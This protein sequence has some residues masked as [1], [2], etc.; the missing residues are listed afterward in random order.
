MSTFGKLFSQY[1]SL[2]TSR[3]PYFIM[4][5]LL[6]AIDHNFHLFRKPKQ[7][8]GGE[9][10]GHRK[11]SKRTQRYHAEIVKEDKTYAYFP[12]M[13]ARMLQT[14]RAFEGSFSAR[15]DVD[16]FNPKQI[17]PTLAMKAPPPTA[18]LLKAPSRFAMKP[19]SSDKPQG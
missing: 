13:V 1:N 19:N 15:S 18:E 2:F 5:I 11:Y 3:Y 12:Y 17:A 4:R 7:S 16:E 8:Q 6:A 14:R 10:A 9:L